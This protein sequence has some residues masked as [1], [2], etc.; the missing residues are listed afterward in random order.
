MPG[1]PCSFGS[2]GGTDGTA[3]RAQVQGLMLFSE[4]TLS[5]A[6]CWVGGE[7]LLAIGLIVFTLVSV[8]LLVTRYWISSHTVLKEQAWRVC[9][10]DSGLL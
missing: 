3:L 8:R 4:R 7:L 6:G 1:R 9:V 2:C 10:Y 5:C